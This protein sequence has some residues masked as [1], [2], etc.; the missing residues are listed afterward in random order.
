M[1]GKGPPQLRCAGLAE[2]PR[3]VVNKA[4]DEPTA[5]AARAVRSAMARASE[6][7]AGIIKR[8]RDGLLMLLPCGWVR[9]RKKPQD[10]RRGITLRIVG[11]GPTGF[12]PCASTGE[13]A[14]TMDWSH[15]NSSVVVRVLGK[16]SAWERR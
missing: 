6:T 9:Y 5:A 13:K 2:Q 1:R 3:I 8:L 14:D 15:W 12:C 10:R 11:I 4:A 7:I 16:T